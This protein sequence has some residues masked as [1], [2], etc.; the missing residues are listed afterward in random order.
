MKKVNLKKQLYQASTKGAL[1]VEVSEPFSS[2]WLS[3]LES[4]RGLY[5]VRSEWR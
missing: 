1:E 3:I 2:D 5:V 4:A